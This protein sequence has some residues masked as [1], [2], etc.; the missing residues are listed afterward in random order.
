MV[1]SIACATHGINEIESLEVADE[2]LF[3]TAQTL[4]FEQRLNELSI[5]SLTEEGSGQKCKVPGVKACLACSQNRKATMAGAEWWGEGGKGR[6]PVLPR[7]WG[8]RKR[9]QTPVGTLAFFSE[10]NR[11]PFGGFWGDR[12]C[13]GTFTFKGSLQLLHCLNCQGTRQK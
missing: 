10:Q 1:R 2:V 8:G 13:D 12:W 5:W 4:T 7:G 3:P 6:S 9:P 11:K